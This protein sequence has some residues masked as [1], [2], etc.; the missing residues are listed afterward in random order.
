MKINIFVSLLTQ[1]TFS[2]IFAHNKKM[3]GCFFIDDIFY[4]SAISCYRINRNIFKKLT[5]TKFHRNSNQT[6]DKTID[7]MN[8]TDLSVHIGE[9]TPRPYEENE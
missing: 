4:F 7:I 8:N 6:E 9:S 2:D 3:K 5:F 1:K